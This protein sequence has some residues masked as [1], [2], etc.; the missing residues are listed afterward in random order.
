MVGIGEKLYVSIFSRARGI[1]PVLLVYCVSEIREVDYQ[2]RYAIFSTPCP[3]VLY[4]T[5]Q[6]TSVF[7]DI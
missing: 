6:Q 2:L 1:W 5:N 3:I 7:R 4:T